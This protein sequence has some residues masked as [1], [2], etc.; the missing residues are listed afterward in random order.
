LGFPLGVG[1]DGARRLAEQING[2]GGLAEVRQT[3]GTTV[4][5]MLANDGASLPR[6]GFEYAEF[7]ILV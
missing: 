6:Q 3:I 2:A 7:V 4:R 5:E 1:A